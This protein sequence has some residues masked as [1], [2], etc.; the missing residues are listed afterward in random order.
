MSWTVA[1]H[2]SGAYADVFFRT[3]S[4]LVTMALGVAVAL[5][6]AALT[7]SRRISTALTGMS[8]ALVLALTVVPAGGWRRFAVEPGALRS[9]AVNVRPEP[10]DLTAWM[11][12]ADGPPNV[13]LFVPLGFFLALLLR[14]P[15]SAAL[16]AAA[17]SLAIECYQASLSTRVGS[18]ADVVANGVGAVL[19]AAAAL[20]VLALTRRPEDAGA[21]R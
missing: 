18:F 13:A 10:G 20:L 21:R 4:V 3:P 17:L 7:P 12:S 8:V 6:V 14:R 15:V 2:R 11:H 9:I 5:L 16:I 19:G 1:A